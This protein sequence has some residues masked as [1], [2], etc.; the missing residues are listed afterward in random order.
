MHFDAEHWLCF[1]QED[2]PL[3]PEWFQEIC[4]SQCEGFGTA[5]DAQQVNHLVQIR[6]SV[7]CFASNVS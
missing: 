4:C 1:R 2:P 7:D 3:S 5:H 6:F